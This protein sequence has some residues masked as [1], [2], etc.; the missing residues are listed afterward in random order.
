MTDNATLAVTTV[1]GHALA[2]ARVRSLLQSSR[3]FGRGAPA[4]L[5]L[6]DLVHDLGAGRDDRAQLAPANDF[7]GARAV[8]PGLA[9]GTPPPHPLE[10]HPAAPPLPPLPT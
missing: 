9:A 10:V 1:N 4:V 8:M 6:E 5:R 2:S 7:G 3:G